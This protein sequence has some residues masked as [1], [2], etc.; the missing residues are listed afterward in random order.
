LFSEN[1]NESIGVL[2]CHTHLE[3]VFR[4]D[5]VSDAVSDGLTEKELDQRQHDFRLLLIKVLVAT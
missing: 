4:E 3:E 2:D 5:L 1:L